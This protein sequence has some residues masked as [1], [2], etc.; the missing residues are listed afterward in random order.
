MLN[1]HIP[2]CPQVR[3]HILSCHELCLPSATLPSNSPS[4]SS[5]VDPHLNRQQ[6]SNTLASLLEIFSFMPDSA[7]EGE[8]W[9]YSI[10][11]N[12]GSPA[13]ALSLAK[14]RPSTLRLPHL[15]RARQ[16]LR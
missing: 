7:E 11:L 13:L 10:L 5:A 15:Q 12:L 14:A 2:S 3:F 1:A 8:F 6:L 16:A 9:G 4:P